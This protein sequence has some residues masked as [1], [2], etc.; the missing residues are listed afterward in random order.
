ML[1]GIGLF[2]GCAITGIETAVAED[3][4]DDYCDTT[5]SNPD[6]NEACEQLQTIQRLVIAL[7][8]SKQSLM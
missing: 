8:V 4:L 7:T 2:I 6:N 3:D 1:A 5:F